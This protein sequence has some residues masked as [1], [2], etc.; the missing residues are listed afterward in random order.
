M[1]RYD[2]KSVKEIPIVKWFLR[3]STEKENQKIN[4]YNNDTRISN[5][6]RGIEFLQSLTTDEMNK[7]LK[8]K[9]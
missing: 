8:L 9:L 3:E 4:S 6:E 5:L 1:D 2:L 7:Y